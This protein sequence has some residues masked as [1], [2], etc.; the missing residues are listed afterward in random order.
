MGKVILVIITT[1][2][3]IGSKAQTTLIPDAVFEQALI[4][5]GLDVGSPDGLVLTSNIDTLTF[6]DV[7]SMNIG[8]L[9]GIEGFTALT[10]LNCSYNLLTSLDVTQNIALETLDCIYNQLTTLDVSQNIALT[11]LSCLRNQLTTLDVT[12]N[13]T[14]T[15]L[16]CHYNQLTSIDVTQNNTLTFLFCGSNPL[17]SLDVTQNA[18]LTKLGCRETPL[19]NIDVTQNTALVYLYCDDTPLTSLDIT[20]NP[21]LLFLDCRYNQLT[22]LDVTQNTALTNFRCNNNQLTSINLTQNTA[23]LFLDCSNNQLTNLDFSQNSVLTDLLCDTNQLTCLNVKNGNNANFIYFEAYGNPNLTC[24]EV[25]NITWST[26]NWT[27]AIDPQTS[28][29]TNCSNAC[30]TVGINEDNFVN[31]SIYPNP[32]TGIVSIDLGELTFNLKVTLT[33]GIGQV[34]LR[35]EYESISSINFDFNAPAGI[36]FLHLEL[37]EQVL[38]KKILKK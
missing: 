4:N 32:T 6:L 22:N 35:K 24:I 8:D 38:T 25:D 34:V 15:W 29:N 3:F 28:F 26:A 33:N 19:T 21:A 27:N 16:Y 18:L 12:Q 9:T 14:L 5:I 7:S 1:F 10:D 37:D 20:Q 17:T 23:L 2:V 11:F 36:Y 13:I 30:S 31:L